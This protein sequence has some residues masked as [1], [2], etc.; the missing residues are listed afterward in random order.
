M[1]F[2]WSC[3][4]SIINALIL[5]DGSNQRFMIS[6][7]IYVRLDYGLTD[8]YSAPNCHTQSSHNYYRSSLCIVGG[9][10][11]E[12]IKRCALVAKKNFICVLI[13]AYQ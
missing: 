1:F 6:R 5:G 9:Q 4:L 10:R 11:R 12:Y 13:Q 7:D 2:W 3:S 8:A